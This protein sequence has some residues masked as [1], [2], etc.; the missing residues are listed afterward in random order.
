[1]QEL[2]TWLTQPVYS[3][4]VLSH[5]ASLFKDCSLLTI[6][7]LYKL[8]LAIFM[9]R[10]HKGTLPKIFDHYFS[11]NASLHDHNTRTKFNL[12]PILCRTN[13]RRFTV[14]LAGPKIWNAIDIGLRNIGSLNAF[15]NEYKLYLISSCV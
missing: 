2:T 12:H 10:Y 8:Q 4:T 3:R 6:T 13:A 15:K 9:Y 7:D 5:T 1:M 14:R 11:L